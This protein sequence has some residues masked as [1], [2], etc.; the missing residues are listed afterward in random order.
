[1]DNIASAIAEQEYVTG[2]KTIEFG[3]RIKLQT[4]KE[5]K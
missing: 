2:L 3:G 5:S 1:M 4:T